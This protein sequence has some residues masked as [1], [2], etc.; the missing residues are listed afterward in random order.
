M[1]TDNPGYE[2]PTR[3]RWVVFTLCCGTSWLL[4]LHRYVF[5]LIKVELDREY[6]LGK[7][8]LGLLDSGFSVFYSVCQVPMG[9]AV[10]VFGAYAM[11]T[12]MIVVWSVGLG[13][14]AWAPTAD[15][16][17]YGRATLGVGQ[18]GVFAALGRI[19][20]DW[21]PSSVRT[22]LQGWVGVFFGRTGGLCA[23]LLIGSLVLGMLEVPWRTAVFGLTLIGFLHAA[24]FATLYRNSPAKHPRVNHA[25]CALIQQGENAGNK[26]KRLGF[27]EMFR[28]MT[29]RSIRNLLTLNLQMILSATADSIFSAWIPLFLAEV[30]GLKF[31]E[32]GF[33]ASLPLLGGAIGGAAG[34]WL[35]DVMIRRTG[36]RRFARS[37]VGFAG[38]AIA[39]GLLLI[40]L[41]WYEDP[42]TFCG[43]LFFVKF[44]SDWSLSTTW[45]AV[46]DIGGQAPATVFAFNN[47]V[48]TL[49]AVLAPALF[50]AIAE[51][52][53]WKMVFITGAVTYI[54]CAI[55]WLP[56]NSTIPVV[57]EAE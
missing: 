35:N 44:F 34:G 8:K 32:M 16:L 38:K 13:L 54:L 1:T 19:S 27:R 36:S 24:L 57:E 47:A 56:F 23:N 55:S 3:F 51:Y 4:Y 10:D 6:G 21:F 31:R 14:H 41:L 28:R 53:S 42:Y 25:E 20:K 33:Y 5:G 45:G 17:W 39:G 22:T 12:A 48:G 49:G 46:T 40:A 9:I 30:H 15:H 26:A 50:G 2:R 29:P 37:A 11:L 7:F 52:A 43:I 18:S